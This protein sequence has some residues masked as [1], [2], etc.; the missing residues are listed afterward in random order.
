MGLLRK[1]HGC[2]GHSEPYL[3][4]APRLEYFHESGSVVKRST[5]FGQYIFLTSALWRTR[6]N[7]EM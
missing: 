3:P 5:V 6:T 7:R 4:W 2:G 1:G